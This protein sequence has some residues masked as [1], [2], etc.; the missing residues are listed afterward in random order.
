MPRQTFDADAIQVS[1]DLWDPASSSKRGNIGDQAAR[2][3]AESHVEKQEGQ[4]GRPETVCAGNGCLHRAKFPAIQHFQGKVNS[5]GA[6]PHGGPNPNY[7]P[8]FNLAF[9]F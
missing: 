1:L 6:Q 8:D 9:E 4:V 3:A 2:Q 7:K 5:K